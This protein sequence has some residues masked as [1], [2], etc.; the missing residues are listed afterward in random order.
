MDVDLESYAPGRPAKPETV[1]K[2]KEM[3]ARIKD[4]PGI[5]SAR[6]AKDV[7]LTSQECSNL[8][9]RL[10]KKGLITIGKADNR[11]LVYTLVEQ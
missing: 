4:H 7:G 1:A 3:L 2:M 6:L 10:Q 5:M 8:A 9:T 11:A